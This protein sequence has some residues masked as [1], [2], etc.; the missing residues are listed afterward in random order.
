MNENFRFAASL[1]NKE[2]IRYLLCDGT[3]LG[4]IREGELLESD[5]D[6]DIAVTA[7]QIDS[8]SKLY[9]VICDKNYDVVEKAYRGILF[10]I[11][12]I[13]QRWPDVYPPRKISIHIY[14]PTGDYH[15]SPAARP[16]GN[17]PYSTSDPRHLLFKIFR[18]IF[19]RFNRKRLTRETATLPWKSFYDIRTFWIPSQFIESLEYISEL[20]CHIPED[21]ED[22]LEYK[23]G[24]WENPVQDWD[25]WEDDG[26]LRT[27]TP[28][29][30]VNI[31]EYT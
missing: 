28:E 26:A 23:Y 31:I 16:H 18:F 1:L 5:A 21:A 10:Q 20:S 12:F 24:N 14:R 22:F 3:L 8:I 17:N 6:I 29:E 7:D 11:D 30:L 4:F 25:Y 19:T 27:E 15:W 2:D 13:P 9:P